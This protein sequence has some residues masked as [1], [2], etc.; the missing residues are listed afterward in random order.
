MKAITFPNVA[1]KNLKRKIHTFPK[2]FPAQ[3]NIILM[4]F[5]RHQ[6]L[7]INTWLP[8]VDQLENKV[9]NLAYLEFPVIYKMNPIG[10]FMLNEGMR[11]GIPD[12]KARERTITLYLD[13]QHFLEQLGIDSEDEIQVMLVTDNGK[14][15]WQENGMFSTEKGSALERLLLEN[16]LISDSNVVY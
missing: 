5:H 4:A 13:K 8:F 7:D 16:R 15:L 10:Q 1:G 11:A 6:Q 14:V 2:D 3:Y 12:Q 9:S